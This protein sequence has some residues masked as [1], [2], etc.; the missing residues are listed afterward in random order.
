MSGRSIRQFK[1]T[2]SSPPYREG[3]K[4]LNYGVA[5]LPHLCYK[6]S[7]VFCLLWGGGL[8][9]YQEGLMLACVNMAL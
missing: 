7:Q 4:R 8:S 1:F 9:R 2:F 6:C 3:G 5:P